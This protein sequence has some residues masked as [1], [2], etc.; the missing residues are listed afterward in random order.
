MLSAVTC[1]TRGFDSF[2]MTGWYPAITNRNDA[3]LLQVLRREVRQDRLVY[4]VVAECALVLPEAQ[5]P[6]P[7]LRVSEACDL[8]DVPI[9]RAVCG[10]Y[11]NIMRFYGARIRSDWSWG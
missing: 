5:A 2:S 1:V 3:K 10:T 4:L 6:Q 9:R 7:G 11:P 8:R